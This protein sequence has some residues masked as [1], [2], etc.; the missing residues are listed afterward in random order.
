[1][2]YNY[3]IILVK[4]ILTPQA[5]LFF[6]FFS[7]C[8]QMWLSVADPPPPSDY[9]ARGCSTKSTLLFRE[10]RRLTWSCELAD[11]YDVANLPTTLLFIAFIALLFLGN[12]REKRKWHYLPALVAP[13]QGMALSTTAT[14]MSDLRRNWR[15][16]VSP[17][18]PASTTTTTSK[19]CKDAQIGFG[20]G[21][22]V[23]ER[24]LRGIW[25]LKMLDW[26]NNFDVGFLG[27]ETT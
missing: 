16:M 24:C 13:E 3:S 10:T 15:E 18:T 9:A 6:I 1:M 14:D 27:D 8:R 7:H 4:T 17:I 26:Q 23:S 12:Q 20:S 5:F 21:F 19:L 25:E 11:S 22:E 2:L